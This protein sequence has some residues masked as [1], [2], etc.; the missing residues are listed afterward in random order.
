MLLYN[1]PTKSQFLKHL[2][3][4]VCLAVAEYHLSKVIELEYPPT[5]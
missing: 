1:E 5:D 4:K 3:I 2:D